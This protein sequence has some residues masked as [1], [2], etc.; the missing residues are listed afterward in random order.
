MAIVMVMVE[1]VARVMTVIRATVMDR[2]MAMAVEP[3]MA[4]AEMQP[5]QKT[6]EITAVGAM[7][8]KYWDPSPRHSLGPCRNVVT[9]LLVEATLATW[10]NL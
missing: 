1:T 7:A 10:C 9:W 2:G 6:A 8:G 3:V 5:R 4:M